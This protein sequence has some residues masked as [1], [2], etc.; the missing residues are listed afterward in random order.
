MRVR[1]VRAR[2]L[3]RTRQSQARVRRVGTRR[4]TEGSSIR[5]FNTE[6]RFNPHRRILAHLR[7]IGGRRDLTQHGFHTKGCQWPRCRI[8]NI[9]NLTCH[10]SHLE[11]FSRVRLDRVLVVIYARL[12]GRHNLTR[13][14]NAHSRRTL[15]NFAILPVRR[16]I[17]YVTL[18]RVPLLFYKR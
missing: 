8:F 5:S 9:L 18:R 16:L 15:L 12:L 1:Q 7:L 6:R 14:P 13:L 10:F 11:R 4:K 17:V 3:R 2:H